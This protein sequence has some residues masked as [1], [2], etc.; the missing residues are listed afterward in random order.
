M[1]LEPEPRSTRSGS[2]IAVSVSFFACVYQSTD[3][4]RDERRTGLEVERAHEVLLAEV[5]VDGALVDRRVGARA[6]DE[7]EHGAGLSS[8]TVN[9]SRSPER[10]ETRAAG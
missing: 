4:R 6:L 8:T 7:P 9:D 3:A 5:E 2:T 10:S 1:E